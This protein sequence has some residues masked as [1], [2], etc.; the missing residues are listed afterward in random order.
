MMIMIIN[1]K[2]MMILQ[3]NGKWSLIYDNDKWSCLDDKW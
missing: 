1:D 3:Y 2:I